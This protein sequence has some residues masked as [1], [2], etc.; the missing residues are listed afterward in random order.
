MLTWKHDTHGHTGTNQ[1]DVFRIVYDN[2]THHLYLHIRN[3][4]ADPNGHTY[5]WQKLNTGEIHTL[6]EIAENITN[7]TKDAGWTFGEILDWVCA[8]KPGTMTMWDRDELNQMIAQTVKD[9]ATSARGQS[10]IDHCVPEILKAADARMET[11]N[12]DSQ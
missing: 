4:A 10:A 1:H 6:K 7:I 2:G 3:Q 11:Q 12:G 8:F 9:H 5:G